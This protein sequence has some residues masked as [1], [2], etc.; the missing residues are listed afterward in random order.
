MPNG[1]CLLWVLWQLPA[2]KLWK[3][4]LEEDLQIFFWKREPE[5]K[6]N[7]FGS[8]SFPYVEK[9]DKMCWF[10]GALENSYG[11]QD[12]TYQADIRDEDPPGRWAP[13][14]LTSEPDCILHPQQK[15]HHF[16]YETLKQ[17]WGY[18]K[19]HPQIISISKDLYC[20]GWSH[21]STSSPRGLVVSGN[22]KTEFTRAWC[23]LLLEVHLFFP[24]DGGPEKE[25]QPKASLSA[26][27]A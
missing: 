4:C 18:F 27:H 26:L 24:R 19:L 11:N 3:W 22:R 20:Q 16:L 13:R 7:L 15:L 8:V 14:Q 1:L 17:L 9:P 12:D 2:E 6:E 23:L 5:G 10:S 21:T 25:Q